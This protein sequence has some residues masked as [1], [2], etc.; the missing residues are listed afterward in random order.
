M[1]VREPVRRWRALWKTSGSGPRLH[2]TER[3]GRLTVD[4][5]RSGSLVQHAVSDHALA[6]LDALT[7]PQTVAA[8]EKERPGLAEARLLDDLL[9]KGLL[10]REGDRYMSLLLPCPEAVSGDPAEN[11]VALTS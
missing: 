8:L 5:T 1:K 2:L 4:D 3:H 11:L 7:K 6:L 10:F 9:A